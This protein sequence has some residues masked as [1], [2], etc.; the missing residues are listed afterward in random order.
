MPDRWDEEYDAVVVGSGNGGMVA[1]LTAANEGLRTLMV[2]KMPAYGGSSALSGGAIWVPNNAELVRSGVRDSRERART[3]LQAII[4]D[5]VAPERI[6][7]FVDNGPP[8]YA[9]LAKSKWIQYR[10]IPGYS[11]YHPEAPGGDPMGRTIE[12]L[13]I[14]ARL[15]KGFDEVNNENVMRIPNGLW[16]TAR[17]FRAMAQAM[18]TWEGRRTTAIVAARSAYAKLVGR[19]MLS[20]GAAGIARLRLALH[21]AGVPLWLSTPMRELIVEGDRVTGIRV[22]RDGRSLCIRARRGV[23]LAAGGFERN[24]EM[25]HEYQ[26]EP[27]NAT[28]TSGAAGNTGDAIK[29]GMAIGAAVD[30][31]D[32]AWWGPGIQMGET[33]RFIIAERTLPGSIVVNSA[34][35]RYLNEALPYVNFVHIMYDQH[36]KTGISHIPSF[37]I[38][39]QH[40]RNRYPVMGVPPR[41]PAPKE[42]T[43]NGDVVIADT[44]AKLA[45]GID[46]PA[47]ALTSTVER[48]NALVAAGRDLDFGKG[49]S[50]YDRYY[51]DPTIEPNPCLAPIGKPPFYACRLVPADLGTKGGLLCDEHARVLRTDGSVIDGLYATGNCSASVMGH[52]Y[53]GAGGTLA[54]AMVFGYIAS[55]HAAGRAPAAQRAS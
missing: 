33:A 32:D 36:H 14:D 52:E 53:P 35:K 17:D 19:K 2:E 1:A 22:E 6:D 31:M 41:L 44:L 26:Q 42:W 51:A 12:P 18:R 4:G 25:R 49:D 7:A 40:F 43:A 45:Q 23:I 47:A 10:W 24:A 38:F 54:P 9:M 5:R 48:W 37:M 39:D 21:D 13:P 20:L 15:L 3:Y 8:M 46:V 16:M 27:I 55:R 34:G 50:A 28:W 30:L 29:A 11:D